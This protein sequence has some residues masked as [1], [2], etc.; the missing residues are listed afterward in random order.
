LQGGK[1]SE[2]GSHSS[3]HHLSDKEKKSFVD[4]LAVKLYQEKQRY[5]DGIEAK[6]AQATSERQHK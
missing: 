3:S 2:P 5:I 6:K 4:L 1:C